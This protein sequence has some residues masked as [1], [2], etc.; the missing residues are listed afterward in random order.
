MDDLEQSIG[1]FSDSSPLKK[2]NDSETCGSNNA[3]SFDV[4]F[5]GTEH[6]SEVGIVDGD[7]M[8]DSKDYDV[9]EDIVDDGDE[10]RDV[11]ENDEAEGD[12]LGS[13]QSKSQSAVDGFDSFEFVH[14][15]ASA[16]SS[17]SLKEEEVVPEASD[18]LAGDKLYTAHINKARHF[19]CVDYPGVIQN[20]DKAL[21]TLGGLDALSKVIAEDLKM[22]LTFRPNDPYSKPTLG[23]YNPT[24]NLLLKIR[25]R[26]KVT[27]G[28]ATCSTSSGDAFEYQVEVIGIVDRVYVFDKLCDFQYLPVVKN[29]DGKYTEILSS[30][31]PNVNDDR[32]EY[33]SR[34]VPIFLPPYSFSRRDIPV[35]YSFDTETVQPGDECENVI[36]IDRKKRMHGAIHITFGYP[37]VPKEPDPI[38]FDH[39][40]KLPNQTDGLD[41]LNKLFE[42]RPL[43]SKAALVA[44]LEKIHTTYL[45]YLLPLVSYYFINGPW[46]NLWCKFGYDPRK[47]PTAKIYQTL[48]YRVR[49]MANRQKVEAKRGQ[50]VLRISHGGQKQQPNTALVQQVVAL[51]SSQI[52]PAAS[53]DISYIFH[54]DHIPPYRQMRYQVCDVRHEE[55]QRRV[56]ENDGQETVCTERDGWCV[57][58]FTD[59]CRDTISDAVEKL[60]DK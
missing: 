21:V 15:D 39:L 46:K 19:V 16:S 48:D 7:N 45:K 28:A 60:F 25:R 40:S 58:D 6:E 5:E 42:K 32:V 4:T 20:Q 56:H 12:D 24:K 2:Q 31:R 10:E 49:S 18:W 29:A 53:L 35:S 52:Q 14:K 50:E 27:Q 8:D 51:G 41:A 55:I 43:W 1:D 44:H 17:D 23:S 9:D 37:E 47:D 57:P 54:P 13:L 33:L 34:C 22:E 38:A 59:V 26:V 11:E 30:I 36:G 3:G